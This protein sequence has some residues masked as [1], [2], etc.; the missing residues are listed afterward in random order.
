MDETMSEEHMALKFINK[1]N[2]ELYFLYMKN[3]FLTPGLRG[4]LYISSL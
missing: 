4:I 1:I 2:E 3:S